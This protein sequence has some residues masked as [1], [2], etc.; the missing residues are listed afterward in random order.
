MLR[1]L[2][3]NCSKPVIAALKPVKLHAY[4]TSSPWLKRTI[5]EATTFIDWGLIFLNIQNETMELH[6]DIYEG[7]FIFG[8]GVMVIDHDAAASELAKPVQKN[9]RFMCVRIVCGSSEVFA[10]NSPSLQQCPMTR[11]LSRDQME[12]DVFTPKI[13]GYDLAAVQTLCHEILNDW[14]NDKK[15]T[16]NVRLR[17]VVTRMFIK[18][19]SDVTLT[20]SDSDDITMQYMR[21]FGE[22]SLFGYYFPFMIGVLGSRQ[23][24]RTDVYDK[25]KAYG[26]NELVTDMTLFAAMFSV[27]TLVMRCVANV[28]RYN[29]N[30]QALTDQEKRNF[31]IESVRLYPTVTSVNRVLE[32]DETVTVCGEPILLK[33]GEEIAYPFICSNRDPKIF[34]KPEAFN[35]NRPQSEYDQVLSWSI[36]PHDCPAKELSILTTL[37]MLETLGE[38]HDFRELHIFELAF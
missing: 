24:I 26:I 1:Q 14:A 12:N 25:L 10:T 38:H 36:G 32:K 6:E 16:N 17:S 34:K 7:N 20:K 30:Y 23:S 37:A 18:I 9:N 3:H 8:Q 35:F 4:K 28:H 22:F 15:M 29:I 5:L 11:K 2:I 21:R 31:V 13:R 27:G 33:A 19:L